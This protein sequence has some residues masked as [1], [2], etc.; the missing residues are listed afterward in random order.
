MA[1]GHRDFTHILSKV[2]AGVGGVCANTPSCEPLLSLC[3]I[4]SLSRPLK[5]NQGIISF[6]W[7]RT[8]LWVIESLLVDTQAPI[9][10]VLE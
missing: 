2:T 7:Q 4:H 8:L 9:G 6:Q 5:S 3:L 10:L 1:K